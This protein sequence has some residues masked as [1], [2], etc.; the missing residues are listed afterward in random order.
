MWKAKAKSEFS[1]NYRDNFAFI[2]SFPEPDN[3]I[4]TRR[5]NRPR[6]FLCYQTSSKHRRKGKRKN[7]KK[8]SHWFLLC[9]LTCGDSSS[10]SSYVKLVPIS[11]PLQNRTNIDPN[12]GASWKS[13]KNFEFKISCYTLLWMGWWTL[14]LVGLWRIDS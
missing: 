13:G 11:L 1:L 5:P 2:V 14:N 12:G 4:E 8:T 9:T 10:I 6:C 3:S 7:P